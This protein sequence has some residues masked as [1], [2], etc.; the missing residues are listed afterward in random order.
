MALILGQASAAE[1]LPWAIST[2]ARQPSTVF[3]ACFSKSS[4]KDSSL[5]RSRILVGC[6]AEQRTPVN[7]RWN[8]KT[9]PA[10]K[11]GMMLGP[12]H[13]G[14]VT[15]SSKNEPKENL[16]ALSQYR[17]RLARGQRA[18]RSN[19]LFDAPD[20]QAAI[21]PLPPDEFYYVIHELGFPEAME[22]LVHGRSEEHTSELQSPCNLVCRLL[23]EKTKR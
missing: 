11:P 19:E 7:G 17:A 12:W 23:L 3:C 15:E 5:G 20:P 22:I 10:P 16:V 2:N 9:P 4:K 13:S 1:T 6:I 14:A 21:R 8:W 18:R